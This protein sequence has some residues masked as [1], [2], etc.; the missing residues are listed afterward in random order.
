MVDVT[1]SNDVALRV[2]DVVFS[3]AEKVLMRMFLLSQIL[4]KNNELEGYRQYILLL[5]DEIYCIASSNLCKY[6]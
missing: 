1:A 5:N 6:T 4:L 2:L 3:K